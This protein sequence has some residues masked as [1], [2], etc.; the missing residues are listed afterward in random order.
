MQ[1]ISLACG[2]AYL[3]ISPKTL[4]RFIAEQKL[5]AYRVGRH[6]RVRIVDL[7]TGAQ[8]TP[9]SIGSH[10]E[11]WKRGIIAFRSM[12]ESC[13]V[14][15]RRFERPRMGLGSLLAFPLSYSGI[16]TDTGHWPPVSALSERRLDHWTMSEWIQRTSG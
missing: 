1:Y 6:W 11:R 10:N 12:P 13:C 2:A 4:R 3:G 7:D 9:T 5:V 15:L 16:G 8:R 14:P